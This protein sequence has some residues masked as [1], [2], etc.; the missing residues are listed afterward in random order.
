VSNIVYGSAQSASIGYWIDRR[1]AG[2]WIVPAAVALATDYAITT[3]RL[4]RIE[5]CV[6]PENQASLR[7][8]QKLGFRYEGRRPRFIHIAGAWRDHEA[9]ALTAE[10]MTDGLLARVPRSVVF[11]VASPGDPGR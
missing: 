3:L 11:P 10:E 7:V 4:H 5:I 6:R 9:Y 2:R 1:Y 8:V